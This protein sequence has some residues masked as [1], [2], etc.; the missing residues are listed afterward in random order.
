MFGLAGSAEL[1]VKRGTR[2]V[3]IPLSSVMRFDHRV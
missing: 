1:L 3:F 2:G